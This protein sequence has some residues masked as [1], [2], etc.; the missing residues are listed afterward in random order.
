MGR[1]KAYFALKIKSIVKIQASWKGLLQR[2]KYEDWKRASIVIQ[3]L[4]RKHQAKNYLEQL[5]QEKRDSQ[6]KAAILIQKTWKMCREKAYFAL[7]IKAIV[8]IQ[9]SWRALLQ[10]RK[11]EEWKRASI[12]IQ[13]LVRTHQAKNY[14]E[15]LRQEK[16]DSQHRAA[17]LIQSTWKMRREKAY[18][19]LKI[20]SIVK[21]QASWRGMLQRRKYEDWKRASIVIQCLVRR[22]QA[23]NYLEQ[24]RQEKRES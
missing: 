5:R 19:A 20:E 12:V 10:R 9:A 24:L 18:F 23:K 21:I 7:K 17:I 13:C 4:V 22:H 8:K 3:C 1:D 6:H 2:R 14:V 15:K 16:R 11:Y